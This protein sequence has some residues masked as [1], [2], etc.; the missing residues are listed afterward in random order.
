MKEEKYK[1]IFKSTFLFAGVQV[2]NILCKV[3]L[4]KIIAVVLGPNGIGIIGLYQSTI[5]SLKTLGDMGI[6][7]SAIKDVSEAEIEYDKSRKISIINNI[8]IGTSIFGGLLTLVLSPFLSRWVFGNEEH[9][10][11]FMAIS[12]VVIFYILGE[13]QLAILKGIRKLKDLAK[14]SIFGTLIGS[15]VGGVLYFFLKEKGIVLALICVSICYFIFP[16][17]YVYR[18]KMK[19]HEV[20][21]FE[22]IN[23][24]KEMLKMGVTLMITT[25]LT[26]FVEFLIRAYILKHSNLEMVGLF[27]VGTTILSGYFG[28]VITALITDYYPRIAAINKKNDLLEEELNKQIKVG[29]LLL[30]PLVVGFVLLMKLFLTLLYS[31]SFITASDYIIFAIFGVLITIASNP[32]DLI[33]VAKS[34]AKLFLFI[35]IG[36]RVI[37]VFL[38]IMGFNIAGLS[39]LGIAFFIL[40]IIHFSIMLLVN[41]YKFKILLHGSTWLS[42]LTVF[43]FALSAVLILKLNLIYLKFFLG[44]SVFCLTLLYS[45]YIMKKE[46][47]INV[48][49]FIKKNK[50]NK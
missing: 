47:G 5:N 36:Y 45:L 43:I 17:I 8:V 42:I 23:E 30:G 27:Q 29:F 46:M 3:I 2:V 40:T 10:Y 16:K 19:Q 32:M 13:S 6:S 48:L 35:C 15:F 9:I 18:L 14:A 26:F 11:S 34:E 24:S 33:L 4:N 37:H 31:E 22:V 21:F 44:I 41:K 39:G 49:S 28:I 1:N 12:I 7:Q 25:F 20:S 38:C 50:L